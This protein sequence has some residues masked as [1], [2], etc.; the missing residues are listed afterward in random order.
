[1]LGSI[2]GVT[3]LRQ[4]NNKI[5]GDLTDHFIRMV[6]LLLRLA[7]DN[8]LGFTQLIKT[9]FHRILNAPAMTPAAFLKSM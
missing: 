2:V 7:R 9:C 3:S 8:G 6:F 1:L 4:S 5:R